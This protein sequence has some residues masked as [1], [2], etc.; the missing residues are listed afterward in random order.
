MDSGATDHITP[1][2]DLFASYKQCTTVYNV[3]TVDGTLLEVA[4]IGSV[5]IDPISLV[6]TVLLVPKLFIS[7]VS[8]QRIAKLEEFK[9]IFRI[10]MHFSIT[11]S[12]DGR[13]DLLKSSEDC[14]TCLVQHPTV[15]GLLTPEQQW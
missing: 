11:R 4:G 10:L 1:L 15:E 7:L 12:T 9:I 14:T 13:L 2:I 8:V 3:Q 5:Y 6:S